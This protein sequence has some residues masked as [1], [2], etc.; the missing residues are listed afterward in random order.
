MKMDKKEKIEQEIEKEKKYITVEKNISKKIMTRE[1]N[2]ENEIEETTTFGERVSDNVAKFGGSWKFI[3]SFTVLMFLWIFLN[4]VILKNKSF[5]PYPFIL[6]NLALSCLAAIQAPIIMMS[7]NRQENKDRKR[8]ENDYKVN[9][10][11]EKEVKLLHEKID[12]LLKEQI[13]IREEIN[14]LQK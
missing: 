7:Q 11:A 12:H 8:S 6:L 2:I 4:T 1:V 9:I 14:K 5:D 10:K 3:I 13:K